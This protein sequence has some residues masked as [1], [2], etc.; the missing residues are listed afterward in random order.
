MTLDTLIILCGALVAFLSIAGFP[1]SF[2][3]PMFFVLGFIVIAL[4]I[5]VRRARG[6]RETAE[7][8]HA[9]T[10]TQHVPQATSYENEMG[11]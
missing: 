5:I 4:G 3:K 11:V 8:K 1:P 9:M 7:R 6:A 2:Y 10:T